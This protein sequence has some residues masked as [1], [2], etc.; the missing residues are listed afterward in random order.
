MAGGNT[1]TLI[2]DASAIPPG[3]YYYNIKLA[4]GNSAGG[5]LVKM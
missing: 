3:I 2:W 5:K 4:D 1:P